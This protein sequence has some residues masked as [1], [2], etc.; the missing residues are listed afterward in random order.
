MLS[1]QPQQGID[2]ES[3]LILSFIVA[4]LYIHILKENL[5]TMTVKHFNEILPYFFIIYKKTL[6]VS[7]FE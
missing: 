5:K 7:K 3:T 6:E 4:A 2:F 1:T